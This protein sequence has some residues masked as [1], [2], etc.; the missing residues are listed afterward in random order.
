MQKP[1]QTQQKIA[2]FGGSFDPPHIAHQQIPLFLLDNHLADEVW[3]VPVK[4][5]PFGKVVTSDEQRVAMLEKM[6]QR[7]T[8]EYPEYAQKLRIEC[9]EIDKN[10]SSY[11]AQTLDA[12]AKQHP[13]KKFSWVIGT[14][15]LEKFHLW[16]E[17]QR[18]TQEFGVFVYP[19]VGY[20]PTSLR[21]GMTYLSNAPEVNVS[22]TEIRQKVKAKETI[23]SL[24]TAQ[25]E[26]HIVQEHLYQ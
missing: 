5:H 7:I 9:W 21:E 16:H 11:T 1:G 10:H 23:T 19:R 12:L 13:D 15:N 20:P 2:L 4:H 24:V 17:Y 6:I 3:F 26:Q 8:E 18:I 14:D 25:V 22:S